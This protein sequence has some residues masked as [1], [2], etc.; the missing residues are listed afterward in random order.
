MVVHAQTVTDGHLRRMKACGVIPTFFAR[1][2]EV[3]GDRHKN[4][5]LGPE[6]AARIDP[7]GS[8]VA[9]GMPFSLHVDTPVLP[10]S[11]LE[12]MSAAVN[13]VTSGGEVLG[14]EQRISA[15][16]AVL[17]YTRYAALCCGGEGRIGRLSPGG[18]AD[19]VVLDRC[20][21]ESDPMSIR[22]I[23]VCA[24]YCGG[25]RVYEA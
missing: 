18:F 17:A 9:L 1:H 14:P 3:W 5:F 4:L 7:C 25:R 21:E 19:F 16:E 8:A 20:I 10:P 24:T 6:R 15:H 22:D 2:V 11:A 13:R 12:S 23:R